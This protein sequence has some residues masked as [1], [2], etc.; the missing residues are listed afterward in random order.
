MWC[1]KCNM[2]TEYN[3]CP[4]CHSKTIPVP[5]NGV[6]WCKE[7]KIPLLKEPRN[8]GEEQSELLCPICGSRVEYLVSDIRPVFPEERLLVELLLNK[9]PYTYM[10]ASVWASN[11]R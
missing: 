4:K 8:R 2:E 6:Y 10:N 11:N 9:E 7:C 3:N 1:G 5:E